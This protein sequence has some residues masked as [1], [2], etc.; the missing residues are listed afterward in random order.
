MACEAPFAK[1]CAA[2]ALSASIFAGCALRDPAL[3]DSPATL[4]PAAAGHRDLLK[5]P[6]PKGKIVAAVYGFRDQTGQYKPAPDSSFSTA[7]T[8][9]AAAILV[10]AMNDSG[11]FV[12]VE[13]E[14]LQNL[15][16]ER[17][18]IRA[19]ETPQDRPSPAIQLPPLTPANVLLEGGVVAYETNVK[20]GGVGVRYLGIGVSDQYRVDQVSVNLRAVDVRTGQILN[21][22][23]TTKTIF[24]H[25][26]QGNVFKFVSFQKL[27]EVEAG[28]TRNE[29]GQ[30]AVK[31][32]IETALI[33]LI[34]QGLREK[35]WAL[36]DEQDMAAQVIQ[37][38][39]RDAE[40]LASN[41]LSEAQETGRRPGI[42]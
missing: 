30:L 8:Q 7:V 3:P 37:D 40:Q 36:R 34:V 24:S 1:A 5:L 18:V 11:W 2:A 39:L 26:L 32:A 22:V 25:G 6:P 42:P 19:I 13:R 4:T 14:G 23:S 12:P 41:V 29:P 35:H 31:E 9:G 20:T 16:T 27:L 17:R 28:V 33:H 21:S 15:L 10:K 38:Y